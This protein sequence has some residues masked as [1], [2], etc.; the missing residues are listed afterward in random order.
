LIINFSFGQDSTKNVPVSNTF[1]SGIFLE[2]QTYITNYPKSFELV[3]NHRFGK[4]S[5][6]AT[7]A[8]GIYSP[9]NIRIGVNYAVRK[10]LQIG[11]GTTKND[12]LQDANIKYSIIQQTTNNKI[13]VSVTY[14]GEFSYD[15]R[16]KKSF[17]YQNYKDIHRFSYFNEIMLARKFCDYFVLQV[18]PI[19]THFNIVESDT[20]GNPIR[21]N[22]NFGISALGKFSITPTLSFFIEFDKNLTK[23]IKETDIYKK[24]K[25]IVAFGIE[26]ST[27]AHSFQI[28]VS[29]GDAINYQKNIVYNQNILY[30]KGDAD[31][32]FKS[33]IVIGF[34]IT[35]VFY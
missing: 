29:T 13:P 19:Y 16:D 8:W 25:P 6:G 30:G 12:K 7:E 34:N 31:W 22:D 33:D 11:L 2:N 32:W 17:D 18:A 27:A 24:P 9:S 14:F 26:K 5:D 3:I 28:F 21:K 35:R 20:A 15:A 10:N 4:I 23:I 1:N